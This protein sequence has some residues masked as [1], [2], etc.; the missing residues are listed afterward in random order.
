MCILRTISEPR[1][2]KG[3]DWNFHAQKKQCF[4]M[5]NRTDVLPPRYPNLPLSYLNH[6][7]WEAILCRLSYL[8]FCFPY[9]PAQ[10][11]LSNPSAL[12]SSHPFWKIQMSLS[13]TKPTKKVCQFYRTDSFYNKKQETYLKK[14]L[15]REVGKS[16][17]EFASFISTCLCKCLAQNFDT[18]FPGVKMG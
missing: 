8:R 2:K 11:V 7:P 9:L 10:L 17:D 4:M 18:A 3:N 12:S 1:S 15:W 5:D 6:H 16:P 14:A 13:L